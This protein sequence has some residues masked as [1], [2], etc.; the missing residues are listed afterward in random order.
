MFFGV[1]VSMLNFDT[2]PRKWG[3]MIL[4]SIIQQEVFLPFL[5]VKLIS[6][7]DLKLKNEEQ[8]NFARTTSF[9]LRSGARDRCPGKFMYYKS[10]FYSVSL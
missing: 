1:N 9:T 3:S 10:K 5:E 2:F 8:V 4:Q 6:Y 7:F